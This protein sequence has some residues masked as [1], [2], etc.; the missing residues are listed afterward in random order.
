[1]SLLPA[2]RSM[3]AGGGRRR[4]GLRS[5]APAAVQ[6]NDVRDIFASY[7]LIDNVVIQ[8]DGQGKS[9]GHGYVT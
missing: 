4:G 3:A 5:G 6:E 8:K 1:M 7:G 9:Q 2:R